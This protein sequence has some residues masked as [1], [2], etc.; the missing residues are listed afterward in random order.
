[1]RRLGELPS[2]HPSAAAD[3]KWR[4]NWPVDSQLSLADVGERGFWSQVRRFDELWQDHLARW[5]ENADRTKETDER[6]DPVGSWRGVCRQYLSP[7]DNAESQKQIEVL[8]EPEEAVTRRLRQIELENPNG[9]VL[10]GIEHRLKDADRLKE[11]IADKMTIKGLKDP[12]EA[13]KT[14]NDAVRYTFCIS[15]W[16]YVAGH[17]HIGRQLESTRYREAYRKNHW[18]VDS[19]YNGV[20]TQ[21]MTPDGGR[22]ELQFHTRE[23][24]CAK[25]QLTHPA[26]SRLRQ[27]TTTPHERAELAA[28]QREVCSAVPRPPGIWQ[29]PDLMVRRKHD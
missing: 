29:I 10:V 25:E 6:D 18:L 22:F 26:Y 28:F 8:R 3:G 27:P 7:D 17:A 2:G 20:N 1:V 24:F 23:S 12:A 13:A 21:W 4:S 19:G 15:A 5:P 14:I 9:A 11:K 16:D